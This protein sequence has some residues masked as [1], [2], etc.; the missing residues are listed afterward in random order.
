MSEFDDP[1]DGELEPVPASKKKRGS[2][3]VPPPEYPGE[4]EA[5]DLDRVLA[6]KP[7]NDFGN[8][9]R[10]IERHGDDMMHITNNGWYVWTGG[11]WDGENGG[12][13]AVKRAHM[14]AQAVRGE[15]KAIRDEPGKWTAED[16]GRLY[17]WAKQSGN[18]ARAHAMLDAAKP[19]MSYPVDVLDPEPFVVAAPNATIELGTMV[20]IRSP[21]RE[22]RIS[23]VLGVD[24]KS[25]AHAPAWYKFLERVQPDAEMRAY[26]QRI[27]GYALTGSMREQCLFIFYGTGR[28][29][30]ST[31]ME[32]MQRVFGQYAMVASADTFLAK[33]DGGGGAQASPD[34][35]RLPGARLVT[36][37]EPPEGGRLDES[38]VKTLTAGDKLPAR[39]LNQSIFEF[40]PTFKAIM[41]T[42]H[43]P[44][45]R[46]SDDG[47]WRRI[48]LV[49]WRVK[50]P[51]S[52][53]DNALSDRL[54]R[55]LPGIL[56]W[57]LTGVE[58]YRAIGLAV[59]QAARDAVDEYRAEQ[60][61]V[62]EFLKAMCDVT[63]DEMDPNTGSR[64]RIGGKR[65][66]QY[67]VAW[68]EEAELEP[69]NAQRFGNKL[70]GHGIEKKKSDGV[71]VYLG[72]KLKTD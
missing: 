20:E 41:P 25:G 66:R 49:P 62:G 8:A 30:K 69:L 65:L 18:Q 64:Y 12:L 24:Y 57:V 50:I 61:P 2:E 52:E 54:A 16:I 32:Q 59:P 38:L 39:H 21:D 31:F 58:E 55:E 45:I 35:A 37:A 1:Y 19:Y 11:Y 26:L 23:R 70:A 34:I 67:Y 17:G 22:D 9:L 3:F 28:N 53:V 40:K 5:G 60:D 72:L 43:R 51:D 33:R 10:L 63:G 7:Q 27:M 4:G 36:V 68:C 13:E 47:I 6:Y 56:Q 42:N 29:G 44:T 15:A 71:T 14:T 48:R 46:G